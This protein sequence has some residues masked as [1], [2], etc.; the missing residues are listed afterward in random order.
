MYDRLHRSST[1]DCSLRSSGWQRGRRPKL[2]RKGGQVRDG[3]QGA[4]QTEMP[5]AMSWLKRQ[6]VAGLAKNDP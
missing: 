6:V 2:R 3:P 5:P 4:D 1:R